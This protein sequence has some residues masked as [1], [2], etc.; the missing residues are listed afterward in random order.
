METTVKR[1]P[2]VAPAVVATRHINQGTQWLQARSLNPFDLVSS[3]CQ[4]PTLK[5]NVITH[6][7][8]PGDG[9]KIIV[10]ICN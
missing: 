4:G 8:H 10:D 9:R 7:A 3:G 1:D 2:R 6:L 5:A